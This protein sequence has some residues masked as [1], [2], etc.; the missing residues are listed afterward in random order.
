MRP[1]R[2]APRLLWAAAALWGALLTVA[3]R[4]A[5]PAPVTLR[6]GFQKSAVNLVILKQQGALGAGPLV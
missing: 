4:A 3:A 5:E 1:P 2:F 6:I